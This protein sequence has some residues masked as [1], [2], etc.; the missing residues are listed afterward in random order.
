MERKRSARDPQQ[1]LLL[2]IDTATDVASV[3][4]IRISDRVLLAEMNWQARRRQTEESLPVV[5]RLL[6]QVSREV[7]DLTALAVTTGP[8]SFTGVRIGIS[9]VKGIGMGL[10][11]SPRFI[12]L[13]ALSVCAFPFLELA[14]SLERH[15]R[16]IA[17]L[18]AG[19]GRYIWVEFPTQGTLY[20]PTADEHRSGRIP[21][22]VEALAENEAPIW[23]VGEVDQPVRDAIRP[24][25]HVYA[26]DPMTGLRRASHLGRLALLHLDAG[27]EDSLDSLAPL[28]LSDPS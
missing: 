16:V 7:D 17:F 18:R 9:I 12:G 6:H 14:V 8:G 3:A 19:R 15:Q 25:E 26:L 11:R 21:R 4:L 28:Y 2:A 23:L 20:R 27:N 24:L 1:S 5:Q 10:S 13:P 22:M